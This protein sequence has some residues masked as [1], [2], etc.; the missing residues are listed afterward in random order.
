[1]YYKCPTDLITE[2][3]ETIIEQSY[4]KTI[5]A[6]YEFDNTLKRTRNENEVTINEFNTDIVKFCNSYSDKEISEIRFI[7]LQYTHKLYF[8]EKV[9]DSLVNCS[10]NLYFELG[11]SGLRINS[12]E[13]RNLDKFEFISG[14]LIPNDNSIIYSRNVIIR[15]MNIYGINEQPKTTNVTFAISESFKANSIQM[16]TTCRMNIVQN[17]KDSED[18][19]NSKVLISYI[20]LYGQE[21]IDLKNSMERLNF[22][23]VKKVNIGE[24]VIGDDVRY[25]N[26][27]KI[28]NLVSFT[29]SKITRTVKQIVNGSCVTVYKVGMVNIHD[30]NYIVN[31]DSEYDETSAIISF[32]DDIKSGLTR[33]LNIYNT[34]L[35]NNS[36]K[37]LKLIKLNKIN[38]SKIYISSS[39]FNNIQI[40][41]YNENT[42]INK[43]TYNDCKFSGSD[44]NISKP[45]KLTFTNCTLD[46]TNIIDISAP[47]IF[48]TKGIW[49]FNKLNIHHISDINKI[50]LEKVEFNGKELHFNNE[51]CSLNGVM[52]DIQ[53][54]LNCKNIKVTNLISTFND[55]CFFTNSLEISNDK[56]TKLLN[57]IFYF[58]YGDIDLNIKS[59]V[60][61]KI[62]TSS[63]E[64][65]KKFN[66]NINDIE[67]RMNVNSINICGIENFPTIDTITNVPLNLELVN[68]D[69]PKAYLSYTG[70]YESKQKSKITFIPSEAQQNIKYKVITNSE[71]L[72][73]LLSYDNSIGNLVFEAVKK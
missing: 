31:N 39:E 35:S 27:V 68:S 22:L 66:I 52:Y 3:D 42:T 2:D 16:Y 48:I 28:D 7:N 54:K 56:V 9:Y 11:Y 10:E 49:N 60:N 30:I 73:E 20:E 23:G 38:M 18:F 65:N 72:I 70:D 67:K 59:S 69:N 24:I 25:G 34:T 29:L 57:N 44:F 6:D 4:F 63:D 43:L 15:N 8:E 1:L 71:K 14:Y 62:I 17:S 41:D 21:F 51:N 61:G 12:S 53:S 40:L 45:T 50:S 5:L 55:T 26:I 32:A 47:F 46:F 36:S 19:D 13:Y 33:S 37:I 58:R 64:P